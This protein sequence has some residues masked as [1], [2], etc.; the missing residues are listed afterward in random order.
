MTAPETTAFRSWWQLVKKTHWT[1]EVGL[2]AIAMRPRRIEQWPAFERQK[3]KHAR[4]LASYHHMAR[5][6]RVQAEYSTV[7]YFFT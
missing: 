1:C 7:S 5:E 3:A 4:G 2:I 6:N